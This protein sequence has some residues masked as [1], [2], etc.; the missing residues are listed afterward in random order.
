MSIEL[1]NVSKK[2]GE[3][4]AVNNVTFSVKEGELMACWVRAAAARPPCCA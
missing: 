3:V 2:F 1:R 4:A